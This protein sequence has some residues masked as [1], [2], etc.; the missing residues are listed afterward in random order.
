MIIYLFNHVNTQLSVI[1]HILQSQTN[2]IY[3]LP[4]S[5]DFSFTNIENELFLNALTDLAS[6]LSS[7]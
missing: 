5:Y 2:D 7:V 3:V 6:D 1:I 4:L